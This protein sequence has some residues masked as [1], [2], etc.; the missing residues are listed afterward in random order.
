MTSTRQ[1]IL[2]AAVGLFSHYG[3]S[4][5]S[6]SDVAQAARL[7][8]TALYN[9]FRNK[10]DLF[11]AVATDLHTRMLATAEAAVEADGTF[12]E[13]LRQLLLTKTSVL[14]LLATSRHGT[15]LLEEAERLVPPELTRSYRDRYERAVASVIERGIR[16]GAVVVAP[17][18]AADVAAL[19]VQAVEGLSHD[20][21]RGL[22]DPER[23]GE[24]V[25][26]LLRLMLEGM[27]RRGAAAGI[28]SAAQRESR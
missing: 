11:R 16:D 14:A 10:E 20:P 3:F 23:F 18:H 1:D 19:L 21:Q 9:H 28:E 12:A 25:D 15:E 22:T 24:K 6:M 4:K 2:E 27:L 7:S 13:R 5:T 17:Q 8:R 26:L